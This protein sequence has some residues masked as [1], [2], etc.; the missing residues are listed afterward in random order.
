VGILALLGAPLLY[1]FNARTFT[2]PLRSDAEVAKV[3]SVQNTV[4][5][6][7]TVGLVL[8]LIAAFTSSIW[9]PGPGGAFRQAQVLGFD[10]TESLMQ[11]WQLG[12]I[13]FPIEY[14][15]RSLFTTVLVADLFMMMNLQ[16][17][18]HTKEFQASPEAES[19]DRLM[20]EI[21]EAGAAPKAQQQPA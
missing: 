7:V 5:I 21:E 12:V 15:V 10:S 1:L 6:V 20:V 13:Q 14:L 16:L 3:G 2:R 19:Y 11:P 17:W 4:L 8:L 9:V 18:K